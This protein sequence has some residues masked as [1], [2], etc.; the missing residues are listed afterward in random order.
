MS[1]QR[2]TLL[3]APTYLLT[4]GDPIWIRV[5]RSMPDATGRPLE[6]APGA[7]TGSAPPF[8]PQSMPSFGALPSPRPAEQS[9]WSSSSIARSTAY[10]L[11]DCLDVL[12]DG[13]TDRSS[14]APPRST[15]GNVSGASSRRSPGSEE[16]MCCA[17]THGS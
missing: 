7:S 12:A 10:C 16:R 11:A 6:A 5:D 15:K 1:R 8:G 9:H 14:P 17:S 3:R 2:L 13:A 4:D